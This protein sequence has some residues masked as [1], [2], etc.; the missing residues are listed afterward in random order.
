[1][2]KNLNL[3]VKKKGLY[4]KGLYYETKDTKFYNVSIFKEDYEGE[5]GFPIFLKEY[6]GKFSLI[7]GS[8]SIKVMELKYNS[9]K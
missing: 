7:S 4:L 9:N 6:K 3:Y 2:A 8:D 5:T 1:M